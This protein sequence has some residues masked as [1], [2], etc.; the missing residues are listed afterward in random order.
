M[1]ER[2]SNDL[3]VFDLYSK[4]SRCEPLLHK[5]LVA[6]YGDI[7]AFC[8]HARRVFVNDQ[9]K[10]RTQ[11]GILVFLKVQWAPFEEQFGRIKSDLEYHTRNLDKITSAI[12]LTSTVDI[13]EEM[14]RKRSL[15]RKNERGSFLRW[16]SEED[17]EEIH[18]GTRKKRHA[19]TGVWF[20]SNDKFEKWLS[21]DNSNHLWCFGRG[22][23]FHSFMD[24]LL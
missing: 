6:I 3:E 17:S 8:R 24:E 5:T 12:T 9:G 1:L 13:Q 7:L 2:L 21:A 19:D 23:S 14:N 10:E 20:L 16:I 18:V 4:R 22:M 11:G 15:E